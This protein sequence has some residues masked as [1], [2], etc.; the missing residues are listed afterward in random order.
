MELLVIV[1]LVVLIPAALLLI[2]SGMKAKAGTLKKNNFLGIRTVDTMRSD[3][4]WKV[5]H[6]ACASTLLGIGVAGLLLAA[7][8]VWSAFNKPEWMYYFTGAY[9]LVV[10]GGVMVAGQQ[11]KKA[12]QGMEV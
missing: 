8:M 12:V 4:T 9:V 11:A 7:G 5:A 1:L 10:S 2:V 3:E 6:Q